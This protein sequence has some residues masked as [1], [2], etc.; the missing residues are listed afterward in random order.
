MPVRCGGESFS[1]ESAWSEAGGVSR[2]NLLGLNM[3]AIIL[4]VGPGGSTDASDRMAAAAACAPH[5]G[6]L[7]SHA[8]PGGFLGVQALEAEASL[9]AGLGQVCV[10][11]G[12]VRNWPKVAGECG[13]QWTHNCLPAKLLANCYF[14]VGDRVF[15]LL[16]GEYAAIIVDLKAG[17]IK[18]VREFIGRAPLYFGSARDLLVAATEPRQ[19]LAGLKMPAIADR[20]SAALWIAGMSWQ[21]DD[22][23]DLVGVRRLR[24]GRVFVVPLGEAIAPAAGAPFWV[25]PSVQPVRLRDRRDVVER[26]FIIFRSVLSDYRALG[27]AGVALSGGIDSPAIWSLSEP[28]AADL[29]PLRGFS[30]VYPGLE[31]D[32]SRFVESIVEF[33]GGEVTRLDMSDFNLVSLFPTLAVVLD[34]PFYYLMP[35]LLPILAAV[36]ESGLPRLFLGTGPDEFLD[37]QDLPLADC[38][39]EGRIV[40]ATNLA[41]RLALTKRGR[42][43]IRAGARKVLNDLLGRRA[44]PRPP[45]IIGPQ[46]F[47]SVALEL[48]RSRESE[49]TEGCLHRRQLLRHYHRYESGKP[50]AAIEQFGA[51]VGVQ[52]Q[53]PLLDQDLVD[54]AFSLPGPLVAMGVLSKPLVRAALK[55]WLPPVV[56]QRGSKTR[57]DCLGALEF[58]RLAKAQGPPS[59]PS[60]IATGLVRKGGVDKPFETAYNGDTTAIGQILSLVALEEWISR[61]A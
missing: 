48:V 39:R 17:V 16:R 42:R 11:S 22:Q 32:E 44:D 21:R 50:L 54:F 8:I 1:R 18:L 57:F 23:S 52:I 13:V 61:R 47:D 24:P 3:G 38:L 6:R 12:M 30:Q 49:A 43:R 59:L 45:S 28:N 46:F 41:A 2:D 58:R 9:W 37:S 29:P 14:S 36:R 27:P 5:R 33:T 25:P 53:H 19:V 31:C 60:L 34:Q 10:I 40:V 26:L 55:G 35:N 56:L 4:V 20:L 7:K 51:S 15:R